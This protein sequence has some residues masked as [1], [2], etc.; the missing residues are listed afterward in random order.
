MTLHI[1]SA[2]TASQL[3]HELA[4]RLAEP[5]H[6]PFGRDVVVVPSVGIRDH[7]VEFLS[8]S[9]P[10]GTAAGPILG[11]VDFI[12]PNAF[13]LR[14]L[15][16]QRADDDPWAQARLRWD[17]LSVLQHEPNLLPGFAEG[18][19]KLA[20]AEKAARLF[21]KYGAQRPSMLADW[22][23]GRLTD[24]FAPLDESRRTGYGW[25]F[26]VWRRV[27]DRLGTS[28][29]EEVV[30][31]TPSVEPNTR[32]WLFA[33]EFLSPAKV[34]LLAGL[35][36]GAPI[37]LYLLQAPDAADNDIDA[38]VV[39]GRA[40][41]RADFQPA[42]FAHP[43]NRSWG[44]IAHETT[45]MVGA[46]ARHT[47]TPVQRL[48]HTSRD[49]LLGRLRD[50]IVADLAEP[51]IGNADR[52][53]QVHLCHGPT[54]QVQ[55]L[56][57]ALLHLFEA[58]PTLTPRDVVVLCTDLE[59]FAPLV[60]PIFGSGGVP[61]P[62]TVV[63]RSITTR[64]QVETALDAVLTA[65]QGRC[66]AT[67][68]LDVLAQP[69]VQASV[70]LTPDDVVLVEQLLPSLD[71]RWGLNAAHRAR[72][73]YPAD[74]D[75][76][77][78]RHAV[79]RMLLG[80]LVQG[81]PGV[82]V[83]SGITPLD[84]VDGQSALAAG[85]FSLLLARLEKVEEAS[86]TAGSL[87]D[88]SAVLTLVTTTLL[89][90]P[91]AE[92]SLLAPVHQLARDLELAAQRDP[93]TAL[94][95]AEFCDT[96][97]ATMSGVPMRSRQWSDTVRV[98]TPERFRGVPARVIALLG[99]D[100]ERLGTGGVDG[101][102]LLAVTAH[103]G[104]RDARREARLGLLTTICA[105]T[106]AVLVVADGY[107]VTDN[108]EIAPAM[109][110]REL[111]DHLADLCG[112]A[113]DGDLPF[114]VHHSRQ[115]TDVV[116]LGVDTGDRRKNAARFVGGPWSFDSALIDIA[117]RVVSGIDA[118]AAT[119]SAAPLP[120]PADDEVSDEVS[121]A[122]L[123]RAMARPAET[124]LRDR[125]GISLPSRDDG[126]D[127]ALEL[128]PSGLGLFDIGDAL[129]AARVDGVGAAEWAASRRLEGGVP[130][131]ML[132]DALLHEVSAEVDALARSVTVDL[133]QRETTSVSVGV[134]G[135][136]CRVRDVVVTHG[137]TVLAF[138]YSK[139]A[140]HMR[141][142]P[143]LSIAALTVHDSDTVWTARVVARAKG[144]AADGGD[145][146]DEGDGAS[147]AVEVFTIAGDTP[148]ARVEHAQA[149]L[150]YAVR[151]RERAMRAP[152]PVFERATWVLEHRSMSDTR[153][154]LASDLRKDALRWAIPT[155][156]T[157]ANAAY[158][159]LATVASGELE[160]DLPEADDAPRRYAKAL[161]QLWT[162]HVSVSQTPE[163]TPK[164]RKASAGAGAASRTKKGDAE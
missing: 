48:N 112:L 134:N 4:Q 85:R 148:E 5:H 97:R 12:F 129:L 155:M 160:H 159:W 78:W 104:D 73:G 68:L 86:R 164:P 50:G 69:Y 83:V 10:G 26:D 154:A 47:D 125:L 93:S 114:V 31:R 53:V 7:L 56:R 149:V 133:D 141:V 33:L 63:D 74:D 55:V 41:A 84:D 38:S 87:A 156:P 151:M 57:D 11:N 99:M 34:S 35:G 32:Y 2:A 37:G 58:D 27:R 103:V 15:G 25:Q 64:T 76:S 59:T 66:T 162:D 75:V 51:I 21:E 9:L 70:G 126:D 29:A 91:A 42:T 108:T 8:R 101:D 163:T 20:R 116:N 16:H 152:L 71:V 161:R 60:A 146:S 118:A 105:A 54:R 14:V 23:E 89:A 115:A 142:V 65:L 94:S 121:I 136:T 106:D 135:S 30:Q 92:R 124:Y 79:D 109:P 67:E 19:R 1:V 95:F 122:E 139:W 100:E 119:T 98:A 96:V 80:A 157:E 62:V 140:H 44:Q 82:E 145:A 150:Q 138:R 110:V 111:I 13:N 144:G 123:A 127:D 61:V 131:R 132:G 143:L 102:D 24:G 147:A 81:A 117:E 39:A 22:A 88:W 6:D 28:P 43:L 45:A 90:L 113:P 72:W 40:V 153:T 158:T 18:R 46:L 120:A 77:T 36:A 130:P 137:S 52:T 128:W 17:I 107:D 49:T 3:A